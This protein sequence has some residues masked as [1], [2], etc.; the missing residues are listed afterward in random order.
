[1]SATLHDRSVGFDLGG[2]ADDSVHKDLSRQA[3]QAAKDIFPYEFFNRF[4]DVVCFAGL[5]TTRLRAHS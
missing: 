2:A 1:M 5:V 3:V 4:D